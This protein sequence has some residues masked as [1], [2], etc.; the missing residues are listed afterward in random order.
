MKVIY[1]AG[2]FRAPTAWGIAQ[3]VRAA[4]AAGLD[5]ARLG[6]MPLIPHANTAHFHG[7]LSDEFWLAGTLE[8]LSRCDAVFVFNW[9]AHAERSVGT[10]GEIAEAAQLG[11][12]VFRSLSDLEG[13]LK[14]GVRG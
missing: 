5:V 10:R 6:A 7:E 12:P 11:L 9:T 3:N 8:L 1:I 13:W 14:E 4:E 2:A